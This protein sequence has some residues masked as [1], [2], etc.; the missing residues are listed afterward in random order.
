MIA[1]A[2]GRRA[3][4]DP[5]VFMNVTRA[6]NDPLTNVG[7]GSEFDHVQDLRRPSRHLTSWCG[8]LLASGLFL[9]AQT[10]RA[11]SAISASSANPAPT[12]VDSGAANGETDD[13]DL[14]FRSRLTA[15]TF[16]RALTPGPGGAIVTTDTIAPFHEAVSLTANR[17]DTPIGEDSLDIQFAG[18]G[19]IWA[20][21]TDEMP[22]A[23]W[24]IAS[25]FLTQRMGPVAV[26]LG[27]Q[28]V[29]GGAAR[30]RR[31]DGALVRGKTDFGLYGAAYGGLTVLPRWDQWYG[32]HTLGDAYEQWSAAPDSIITPARGENWMSGMNVGW[33]DERIGS[34]GVSFHHQ[35][36]NQSIADESMGVG[37]RLG[38]W[39]PVGLVADAIYSLAQGS[40]S[41]VRVVADWAL[42]KSEKRSVGMGLRGE[43]LHTLP[44]ALLSQA[45]VLSVFSFEQVTEAGGELDVQLPLGLRVGLG[46]FGQDYGEGSPG[47]RLRGTVQLLTGEQEQ[48]LLRLVVSRVALETNAYTQLRLAGRFPLWPRL[49]AYTDLYQYFYDEPIKGHDTSTFAAAHLGYAATKYWS[50]RLGGSASQSP[51]A[52]LDLQVMAQ[53]TL[54]L[55]RRDQ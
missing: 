18:Y 10:G 37:L 34:L 45:S 20:G 13:H 29:I 11:Q 9:L 54:E 23:T 48:T 30:Y 7:R 3:G 14:V 35:A 42:A 39:S 46:A 27:R 16:Q 8:Y 26:S 55:D 19:Q 36:E 28:P 50:A 51:A 15:A 2:F 25:A 38:S 31:L 41:D 24:D 21:Q 12:S 33:T 1:A 49:T 43:L 44:S 52:A 17:V 6:R 47:A 22:L 53:L 32:T 5:D 40:W 4:R